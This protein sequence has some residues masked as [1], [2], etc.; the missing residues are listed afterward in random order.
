M[1]PEEFSELVMPILE[2]KW[3]ERCF[4]RNPG[5][6]K[7]LSFDFED[8]RSP[9]GRIAPVELLD[10]ELIWSSIVGKRFLPRGEWSRVA[11]REE[12]VFQ[13]PQC[14]SELRA[15]SEQ[16]SI[17]M[18]PTSTRPVDDRLVSKVGVYIVGFH[19]F[20]GKF[21]PLWI[22]DFRMAKGVDHFIDYITSAG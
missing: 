22:T 8:Y 15:R 10:S 16:Y 14:K 12:R 19:F 9:A 2:E 20:T 21:D 18:W 17:N 7:L 11:D 5:F 4:C 13:C 3:L 6:L 1:R